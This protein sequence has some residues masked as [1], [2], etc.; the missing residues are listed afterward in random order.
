MGSLPR[1]VARHQLFT[2]F[3]LSYVIGWSMLPFGSFIAFAP[4]LSVLIVVPLAE[5]RA[6]LRRVGARMVRWRVA[7]VWYLL[8]VGVPLLVHAVAI[9]ANVIAGAPSPAWQQFDPWYSV[10]L[11]FGLSLV[12]PLEGALGEEP[13]WR[14]FAQP[15]LQRR[16]SPLAATAVL[17][18]AV[19]G[20]HLP[21]VFLPQFDLTP[22]DIL[23]TLAVTFWYAWLFNRTGGSALLTLVAHAT[24]GT[25][26]TNA[27][28]TAGADTA[29]ERVAWMLASVTLAIV[30]LLADR[31]AWRAPDAASRTEP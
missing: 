28:W 13:G 31:R 8:A 16:R 6:G 7:P 26:D 5:G 2:F 23:S 30:L 18:L 29:R 24:E 3:A 22:V 19:T 4:L 14:G 17:A 27:L 20:W 1:G 10:L 12:N 9:T 15:E 21:L 11:V 25:I